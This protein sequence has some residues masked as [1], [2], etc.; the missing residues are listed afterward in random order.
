RYS[1]R[2]G[3]YAVKYFNPDPVLANPDQI[4]QALA[5]FV[6]RGQLERSLVAE[7]ATHWV[8]VHELVS[9][10][11]GYRVLDYYSQTAR[12]LI[13]NQIELTGLE[14]HSIISGV[15]AGLVELKKIAARSHGNLK[16]ENVLLDRRKRRGAY[17][18]ALVDAAA[19][20][21]L[22]AA[23]DAERRDLCAVGN[24]IHDLVIPDPRSVHHAGPSPRW[25]ALGP[26]GE[27]W[28]SLCNDLIADDADRL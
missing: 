9:G 6:E 17:A 12:T 13:Q 20:W 10:E 7:G 15:V 18:V 28:R 2:R 16:P 11:G 26:V 1:R 8:R 14:L 25:E 22:G 5:D 24:L 4:K 23:G 21:Q 3:D 27:S 19:T